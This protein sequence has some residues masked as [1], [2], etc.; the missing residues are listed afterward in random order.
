MFLTHQHAKIDK[1]GLFGDDPTACS[2][3]EHNIHR[4]WFYVATKES[5]EDF[6]V[7]P[8]LMLSNERLL[9]SLVSEQGHGLLMEGVL[10]VTPDHVN[11]SGRWMMEPLESIE[12]FESAEGVAY[13]YLVQGDV[14]YIYGDAEITKQQGAQ[15]E[16]LFSSTVMSGCC[17]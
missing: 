8:M 1:A 14:T 16:T 4:P 5:S 12:R 15:R 17:R 10:L 7:H 3:V 11:Q 9:Q 2:F 6:D 13:A